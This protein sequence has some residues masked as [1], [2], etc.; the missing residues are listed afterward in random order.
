MNQTAATLMSVVML[1]A[2]VL[3]VFGSKFALGREHRKQG[4]MMIAVGVILIG[5]VLIWAV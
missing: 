5:N 4:G 1:A 3:I 2:L